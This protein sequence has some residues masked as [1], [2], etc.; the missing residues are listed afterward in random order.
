MAHVLVLDYGELLGSGG[1]TEWS[2]VW[3]VTLGIVPVGPQ[4]W[5]SHLITQ[6]GSCVCMW[7]EAGYMCFNLRSHHLVGSGIVQE[8]LR[9]FFELCL[10]YRASG[11]SL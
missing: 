5:C 10:E 8:V 2:M 3:F 11:V 4:A 1:C 6:P 7:P 9:M